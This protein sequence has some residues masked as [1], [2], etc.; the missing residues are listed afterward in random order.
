MFESHSEYQLSDTLIQRDLALGRNSFA[1]AS[2]NLDLKI[3]LLHQN[4]CRSLSIDD[5]AAKNFNILATSLSVLHNYFDD[6][7]LFSDLYFSKTILSMQWPWIQ[8][9]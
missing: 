4:N 1:E 5:S 8:H 3:F 6:P 9:N 7:I 2:E